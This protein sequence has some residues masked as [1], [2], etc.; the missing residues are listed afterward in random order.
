MSSSLEELLVR[1]ASEALLP[2]LAIKE[3]TPE[4]PP[5][6]ASTE[7]PNDPPPAPSNEDRLSWIEDGPSAREAGGLRPP[8]ARTRPSGWCGWGGRERPVWVPEV[9]CVGGW[10]KKAGG[11]AIP[12]P[13][14]A[15]VF[16][17]P[18][19]TAFRMEERR[20]S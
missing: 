13:G 12:T 4:N 20:S 18:S 6:G 9:L 1:L 15:G 16:S 8:R 14:G 3:L 2:P 10:L 17:G 5:I 19:R 7:D 11:A